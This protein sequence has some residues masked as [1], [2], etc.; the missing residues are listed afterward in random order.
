ME[1]NFCL[2]R[3]N[4]SQNVVFSNHQN[5]WFY[6]GGFNK[7]TIDQWKFS[8]WF[9][10]SVFVDFRA[11]RPDRRLVAR[12][13]CESVVWGFYEPVAG[14]FSVCK[15]AMAAIFTLRH[16]RSAAFSVE[17][18]HFFWLLRPCTR[19]LPLSVHFPYCLTGCHPEWLWIFLGNIAKVPDVSR[20]SGR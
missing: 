8:A 6:K 2:T 7:S 11:N 5:A 18:K 10:V 20:L 19:C 1:R 14:N 13:T 3:W 12:A 4:S 15:F 16:W 9:F 17:T